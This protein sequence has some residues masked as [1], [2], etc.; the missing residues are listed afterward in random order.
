MHV[1]RPTRIVNKKSVRAQFYVG[2]YRDESTGKWRTVPLKTPDKEIAKKRLHDHVVELQREREGFD[3]PK[4]QRDAGR[5]SLTK[6][7]EEYVADLKAQE[8]DAQ[9]VKDTSRRILRVMREAQWTALNEVT[10]AGYIAWRAG[11]KCSAKTKKEYQVSMSAFCNWLL[12]AGKIAQ[13]P[14]KNVSRVET[15]GRHVRRARPFTEAELTQ[16]FRVSGERAAVYQMLFYS[17]QRKSEVYLLRWRDLV[18]SGAAPAAFFRESTTKDNANRWVPLPLPLAA[19]LQQSHRPEYSPERRVFWHLF[20]NRDTF[21]KDLKAAG[22]VRVG[23]DGDVV[24][25]HSFRKSIGAIGSKYGVSQ[26]ATQEIFGHSD[27]NLTANIYTQ[28]DAETLRAQL[29]KLPWIDA[30]ICA[31]DSGAS[32]H[33]VSFPDKPSDEP[34]I[35][36]AVGAEE[37]SRALASPVTTGQ[38]V[39]MVDLTGLEPVTF[40]MSRKRSN[41]LS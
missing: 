23:S 20:P 35:P 21:V 7:V 18:L 25:F 13:N 40:S 6:H 9:H 14:M 41:Q 12:K 8:L 28:I 39:K 29:G 36:K 15:R 11:L 19:A 37:L 32:G 30:H 2:R 16:L 1:F 4:V 5:Q 22:I 26:K 27:A 38:T 31:H 10:T 3:S 24:H 34:A 17:G 33:L